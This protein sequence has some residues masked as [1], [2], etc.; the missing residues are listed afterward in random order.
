MRS[1]LILCSGGA[2]SGKSE[3]AEKLAL[4][5]AG[6]KAYLATAQIFDD[7]IKARVEKHQER[8][9]IE[10]HNY[11]VPMNISKEFPI[12]CETNDVFL[13][14]CITMYIMNYVMAYE[15]ENNLEEIILQEMNILYEALTATSG[16]TLICVT[17]EL[18]LGIVP[19]DPLSRLFRDIA[20]KVNRFIADHADEVYFTVSGITIEI[21]SKGVK[22]DG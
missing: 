6:E 17:N 22:I 21:K 9:G 13:L 5:L 12:L 16:K 19:E 3:F 18:G 15:K 8:R 1:K 14:D 20:G 11:E 7:E 10:W 2:R 4:S